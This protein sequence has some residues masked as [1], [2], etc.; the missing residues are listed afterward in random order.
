L[1]TYVYFNSAITSEQTI[2]LIE[3][4]QAMQSSSKLTP[5]YLATSIGPYLRAI[6]EIQHIV[7]EI[8]ERT[9]F[10]A[11]INTISASIQHAHIRVN[12][13]GAPD[14]IHLIKTLI[15]PWKKQNEKNVQQFRGTEQTAATE[16]ENSKGASETKRLRVELT[17]GLVQLA[18]ELMTQ[19]APNLAPESKKAFGKRLLPH[20]EILT[21]S[22]LEIASDETTTAQVS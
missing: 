3:S 13:D 15:L 4:D 5:E 12:I 1:T 20:L 10:E 14:A 11:H 7:D 6:A 17:R 22:T 21:L 19:I 18:T 16:A 2:F 9:A 8:L